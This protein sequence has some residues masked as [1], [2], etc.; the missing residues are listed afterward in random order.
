MRQR[1]SLKPYIKA[2]RIQRR[3]SMD[4]FINQTFIFPLHGPVGQHNY[5]GV[6]AM[7]VADWF[8]NPWGPMW[9]KKSP[10]SVRTLIREL[11]KGRNRFK[12]SINQSTCNVKRKVYLIGGEIGVSNQNLPVSMTKM[13]FFS[14][15]MQQ[16][17][18]CVKWRS[19]IPERRTGKS[20][21]EWSNIDTAELWVE[22]L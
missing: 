3:V 6:I 18:G 14:W 20:E 16:E 12:Q 22:W 15:S 8:S 13:M 10:S 11:P 5:L 4:P 17:T 9:R 7:P 1:M 21:T 19:A 2:K